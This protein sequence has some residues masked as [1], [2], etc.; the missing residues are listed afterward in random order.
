[1]KHIYCEFGI[2]ASTYHKFIIGIEKKNVHCI[3][4]SESTGH[5]DLSI[6]EF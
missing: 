1:M 3:W 4:L 2:S 5:E 6:R